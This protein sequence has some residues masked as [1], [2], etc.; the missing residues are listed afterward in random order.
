MEL[1]WNCTIPNQYHGKGPS[2]FIEEALMHEF[3][4]V[5]TTL[6]SGFHTGFFVREGNVSII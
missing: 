2:A 6:H 5:Q 1:P 3:Q 4:M